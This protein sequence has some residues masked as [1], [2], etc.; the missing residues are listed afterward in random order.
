M[1]LSNVA[2]N[3][4]EPE[5]TRTLTLATT[6]QLTGAG[7]FTKGDAGTLA[8]SASQNFAGSAVVSAGTMVLSSAA[9]F[10]AASNVTVNAGA[11]FSNNSSVALSRDLVLAEGAIVAGTGAFA[12]TSLTITGDLSDGFTT[13]AMGSTSLTK[14]NT[15]AMTLTGITNGS[16]TLFS[17]SALTGTFSALTVN[18]TALTNIGSGN[19]AGSAGGFDYTFTDSSNVLGVVPE[20]ST[21]A[22]VGLGLATLLWMRRKRSA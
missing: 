17:G 12:P 7:G 6:D 15:L 21:M 8:I 1:G 9:T 2:G 13:F 18:G 11:T 20:P 14:S 3:R 16:F 4:I 22:L 19:F 10:T 5:A